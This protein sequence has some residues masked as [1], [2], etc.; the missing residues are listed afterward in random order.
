MET[1]K[2]YILD[3]MNE[4]KEFIVERA[5]YTFDEEEKQ[6]IDKDE[7]INKYCLLYLDGPTIDYDTDELTGHFFDL[8]EWY[9]YKNI[10]NKINGNE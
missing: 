4:I 8:G 10:L 6:N 7:I 2:Q 5:I 9:A 1:L 3:E